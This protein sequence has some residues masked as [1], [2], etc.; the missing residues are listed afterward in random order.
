MDVKNFND[1]NVICE[2][3]GEFARNT[4]KWIAEIE[5]THK[6]AKIVLEMVK[7]YLESTANK[8]CKKEVENENN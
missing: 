7:L 3:E 2:A 8:Y 1:F 4:R 5:E 6:D